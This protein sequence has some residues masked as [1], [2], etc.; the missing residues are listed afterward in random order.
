MAKKWRTNRGMLILSM[1][2]TSFNGSVALLEG[3]KLIAEVN[4]DSFITHS[5][6]LLPSIDLML[7]TKGLH[8]KDINGFA[9]AVGPG[10]FTG[11]RIGMSTV[12]S[13][14]FVVQK[15]VAPVS[16]L[17][18]SALKLRGP[19]VRLMCPMIDAKKGEIYA[20][21]YESDGLGLKEIIHQTC[22]TPDLFLSQLPSNRLIHFIGSGCQTY[23]KEI[24]K[25]LKDKARFSLRSLFTAYEV[26]QL[27]HEIFM[28]K[29]EVDF[30]EIEPLY[31][32]KSQAEENY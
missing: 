20:A 10:S 32:R 22:S 3:N 19:Y 7:K 31:L 13:M 16:N 9:L 21:L 15:K 1:D 25:Y 23:K 18:A 30:R 17:K 8:I 4:S 11:I 5:E 2:T 29:K 14:A 12:K 6:R 24:F 26:G 28:E 27:G